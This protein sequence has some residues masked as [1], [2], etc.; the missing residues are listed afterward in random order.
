MIQAETIKKNLCMFAGCEADLSEYGITNDN[1]ITLCTKCDNA[2]VDDAPE[3][4]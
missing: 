4:V 3:R 1:G 2:Q